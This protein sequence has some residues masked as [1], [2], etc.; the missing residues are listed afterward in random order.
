MLKRKEAASQPEDFTEGSFLPLIGDGEADPDKV[1]TLLLC[2]G[3]V[4]WDL[5]VDRKTRKNGEKFATPRVERLY[6]TP[7]EEIKAATDPIPTHKKV[8]WDP[9]DK[10]KIGTRTNHTQHHWNQ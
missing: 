10:R 8:W 6:H 7:T 9:Q 3:R 4:T 5:M 1:E 2:S